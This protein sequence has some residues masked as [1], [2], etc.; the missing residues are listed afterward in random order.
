MKYEV[1]L[2][3]GMNYEYGEV[4]PE[5]QLLESARAN[6]VSETFDETAF[7]GADG[8]LYRLVVKVEFQPMPEDMQKKLDAMGYCLHTRGTTC[9][10]CLEEAETEA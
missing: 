4:I 7:L 2:P 3:E 9:H 5:E 8:K 6:A 10:H 1:I